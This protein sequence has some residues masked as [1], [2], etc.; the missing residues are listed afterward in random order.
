MPGVQP[1]PAGVR[2]LACGLHTA[3]A[4]VSLPDSQ[5][6]LFVVTVAVAHYGGRAMIGVASPALPPPLPPSPGTAS[7]EDIVVLAKKLT[8]ADANNPV[9][10]KLRA[11]TRSRGTI[12]SVGESTDAEGGT[13]MGGAGQPAAGSLS[14]TQPLGEGVEQGV[15]GNDVVASSGG[16][17]GTSSAGATSPQQVQLEDK[18]VAGSIQG[19]NPGEEISNMAAPK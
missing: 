13:S 12:P 15:A 6:V 11:R 1:S 4:Y 5:A 19:D 16:A 9:I 8:A 7:A 17:G 3:S 10:Q 2:C 18:Q 14:G